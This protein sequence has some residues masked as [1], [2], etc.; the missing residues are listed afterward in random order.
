VLHSAAPAAEADGAGLGGEAEPFV[1][2]VPD[3]SS[4]TGEQAER[5]AILAKTID[6][7]IRLIES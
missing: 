2:G 4:S 5:S 3:V 6:S 1:S 7:R